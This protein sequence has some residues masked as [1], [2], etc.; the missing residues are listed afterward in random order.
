[1]HKRDLEAYRPLFA[2]YLDIQ[3]GRD[4]D[5]L[6]E[7]E[8]KGRWKSFLGKWN[9][10]E[11]AEGWYDP[12]MKTK[13]DDRYV[14]RPPIPRR[15][16][17]GD[18]APRLPG[19]AGSTGVRSQDSDEEEDG[20][21]PTLP[22]TEQSQY[23]PGVPRFQDLQ[24][25]QE[26]VEEDREAERADRRYERKQERKLEKER[27]EELAPRAAPGTRERQLEKKRESAAANRA[28]RDAKEG[29]EVE[30]GDGDL[31]GD[32]EDAHKRELKAMER[33][34]NEREVRKEEVLRARAAEREERMVEAR[35]K[36][37]KTMDMLREIAKQRYG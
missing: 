10:K 26:Q 20:Y 19:P 18:A 35:R 29:G 15:G 28:F 11:L 1:M 9:R 34:K 37:A 3:K 2:E 14:G 27:L 23:G 5:E 31:L 21:G 8:V 30:V 13:A 33:K 6:G 25:R 16:I 36:E 7:D 32:D 12:E 4:I 22:K 24:M 17:E